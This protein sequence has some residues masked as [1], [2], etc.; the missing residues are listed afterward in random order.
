MLEC[1]KKIFVELLRLFACL[2][3]QPLTLQQRK[4]ERRWRVARAIGPVARDGQAA[5]DALR[6]RAR[7]WRSRSQ[8]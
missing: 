8:G 6:P 2:L 4:R 1:Q 5:K 7:G 3:E